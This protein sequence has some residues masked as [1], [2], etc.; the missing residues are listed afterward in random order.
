MIFIQHRRTFVKHLWLLLEWELRI[1]LVLWTT[2]TSALFWAFFNVKSV[3]VQNGKRYVNCILVDGFALVWCLEFLVFF[4]VH[5]A[6]I[7]VV[8]FIK[9][10][11]NFLMNCTFTYTLVFFLRLLILRR[12]FRW[13][14]PRLHIFEFVFQNLTRLVNH[15]AINVRQTLPLTLQSLNI[16]FWC[17]SWQIFTSIYFSQIKLLGNDSIIFLFS[18]DSEIFS[19][20][21]LCLYG[22]TFL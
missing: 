6:L 19:I 8:Y 5:W 22:C 3:D 15:M 20:S 2:R 10:K 13:R 4:H 17:K 12:S 18:F 16:F 7:F 11:L 21:D 9:V 1:K 14:Q